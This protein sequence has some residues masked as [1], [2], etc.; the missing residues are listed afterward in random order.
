MEFTDILIPAAIL[1]ALGAFFGILLAVASRV[2]AVKVD[3]RV[4]QIRD[5]LPGANCGGCGYSGC[6][7]LAA[8]IVEGRAPCGAC[9]VGGDEA[10]AKIATVMGVTAEKQVRMR[11]LVMCMG[12]HENASKKY[13]YEGVNDCLAAT[14][15]SGGDKACAFGCLGLGSCV[16][17]CKFDAVALQNGVAAVDPEK[18]SGCGACVGACP[19]KLIRL[20]PYDTP[21]AVACAS[22]DKGAVVNKQC[23][24]GCIGCMQCQRVCEAQAITVKDALAEIDHAKCIGCGKCV[25]KCPRHIIVPGRDGCAQIKC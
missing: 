3:E 25:E 9:P 4:P 22:R 24:V 11:A 23:K 12:N 5:A 8:A 21:F 19:K 2:F 15:L 13:M 17:V 18:C 20:I 1:A 7:A 16:A 14:R 6:D 10:A